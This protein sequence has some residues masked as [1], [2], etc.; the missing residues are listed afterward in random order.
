MAE[1]VERR[2][3]HVS[4]SVFPLLYV[5]DALT[6]PQLQLVLVAGTVFA[7]SLEFLRLVVGVKWSLFD[8]LT[9]EYEQNNLA[10]YALYTFSGTAAGLLFTPAVAIPSMFMLT[11]G[12]PISGLL[13][14]S[15]LRQVK[16][17]RVLAVMFV[18][19]TLIALPF[20]PP[21]VA[22]L[23]GAGATL[24]DGVKP[25]IR[26]YVIDDN[27]TIPLV[28]GGAMAGSLWLL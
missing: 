27:L 22:A 13:G 21:L 15:E 10:G 4:G 9:R 26:G 20:L 1:E 19:C 2:L 12:D 24:A 11:V 3:V 23:G 6:W 18:V 14:D 7:A 28:A 5:F 16:R 8:R 17:V 25:V